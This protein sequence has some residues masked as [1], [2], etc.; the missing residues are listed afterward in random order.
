MIYSVFMLHRTVTCSYPAHSVI[1]RYILFHDS[2]ITGCWIEF[3]LL[4][5][6]ILFI[7]PI[8]NSLHLL[9]PRTSSPSLPTPSPAQQ[10][11]VC[12]LCLGVCFKDMFICVIFYIP[13]INWHHMVFVSLT[14]L[15]ML[16]SGCIHVTVSGITSFFLMANVPLCVCVYHVFFIH[17]SVDGHLDCFHVLAV[18]NS[19][20]MNLD[21]CIFSN[22][23]FWY[24]LRSGITGLYGNFFFGH[25][26]GLWD[27]RSPTRDQIWALGSENT[28]S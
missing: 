5:S 19:A 2:F 23:S 1:H 9:V 26:M 24:M 20:A 17:S 28:E 18:V 25:T 7:H 8:Y 13:H 21:A 11:Q 6:R 12:S 22:Y 4:Y 14:L 10:P 3:C 15:I 27:F 16:I